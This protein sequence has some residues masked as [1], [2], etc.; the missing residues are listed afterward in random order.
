LPSGGDSRYE[1]R[2]SPHWLKM[3]CE[4]RQEFVVGGF[5]DPQGVRKGL[6]ALLVGYFDNDDS[7]YAGKLGTGF[8]TK[9]LLELELGWTPWKFGSRPSPRRWDYRAYTRTGCVP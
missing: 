5:T 4:A 9:L 7:V 6:G 3:K 8:N 2:R 1:H